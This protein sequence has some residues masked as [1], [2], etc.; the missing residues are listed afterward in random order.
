[1]ED[2]PTWGASGQCSSG[3]SRRGSELGDAR[4]RAGER[5]TGL[6]SLKL[7][8]TT[9]PCLAPRP[10]TLQS[11]LGLQSWFAVPSGQYW[12]GYGAAGRRPGLVRSH[13]PVQVLRGEQRSWGLLP[14]ASFPC[15]HCGSTQFRV[16]LPVRTTP[17]RSV[18]CQGGWAGREV[19]SASPVALLV[20]PLTESHT[21]AATSQ[22][23]H[24][25]W[26]LLP[27][28]AW[29]AGLRAHVQVASRKREFRIG[30][31]DRDSVQDSALTWRI[32][33]PSQVSRKGKITSTFSKHGNLTAN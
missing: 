7:L 13:F 10:R 18:P 20:L 26:A 23:D 4:L 14:H 11:V 6:R 2:V 32:F 24:E 28:R 33:T 3:R 22:C 29:K 1:M 8:P 30:D 16:V 17:S 5:W 31:Q 15:T 21:S 12:H 9:Q 27:L 25:P 19:A